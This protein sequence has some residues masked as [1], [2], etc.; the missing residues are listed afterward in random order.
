M[1]AT[2]LRFL[3]VFAAVV[4]ASG[5]AFAD[6]QPLTLKIGDPAPEYKVA[7]WLKG[8]PVPRLESGRIYLLEFWAT[9]CAPCIKALPHLKELSGQYKDEVT[10]IAIGQ[11]YEWE[12]VDSVRQFVRK[13]D[14]LMPYAVGLDTLHGEGE[15]LYDRWGPPAGFRGLP[16]TIIVDESGRI[17]WTGMPTDVDKPLQQIV[18]GTYDIRAAR[19]Q[20][21]ADY[22]AALLDS[23]EQESFRTMLADKDY[24]AVIERVDKQVARDL[25]QEAQLYP[26]KLMALLQTDTSEAIAYARL[27]P[28]E[29]QGAAAE[30]LAGEADLPPSADEFIVQ[31]LEKTVAGNP[32]AHVVTWQTLAGVHHRLGNLDRA[33]RAQQTALDKSEA[34]GYEEFSARLRATLKEYLAEKSDQRG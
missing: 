12:T 11:P 25:A 17:A 29:L 33:I 19:R 30:L 6:S 16:V 28:P 26:F 13:R 9:R 18:A 4:T 22:Q 14:E 32:D 24:A 7:T 10:F 21:E 3:F 20:Q 8:E 31:Q 23:G 34:M 5:G 27:L 2:A 15:R 1:K